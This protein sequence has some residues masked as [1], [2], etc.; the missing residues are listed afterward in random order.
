[1]CDLGAGRRTYAQVR[2]AS[3]CAEAETSE[4]VGK[5]VILNTETVDGPM[6]KARV[7]RAVW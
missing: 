2:D 6:G 3:L 1:V 7:N 4:L 5:Q